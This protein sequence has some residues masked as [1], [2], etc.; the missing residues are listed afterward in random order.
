MRIT[1]AIALLVLASV[2]LSAASCSTTETDDTTGL[3]TVS[4]TSVSQSTASETEEIT[5]SGSESTMPETSLPE[6]EETE[7][8]AMGSLVMKI[9]STV[10]D[11][12][13]EE[14]ASVED[15]KKL[16]AS[17]LTIQMSM[18]GGF[19][20]VGPIGQ[21]IARDDKQTTT[22]PGDI[23][24]YSGNQIVVFYGS[25][26]WSYTR[27]GKIN[28]TEKELKDLLSNG[29]VTVTLSLG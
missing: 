26:S 17:G 25:N 4:Q 16:A 20:Q 22:E 19:E 9:G 23:V 29:D 7:A 24:L 13:W 6:T 15:L 8:P 21:S 27:L 5:A 28:L 14:N 12:T 1:R 11:V 2:T 3:A 18:Y 10:V